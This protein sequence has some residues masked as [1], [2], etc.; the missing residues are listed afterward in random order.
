MV[1]KQSEIGRDAQLSMLMRH[2]WQAEIERAIDKV[3]LGVIP[4]KKRTK[5]DKWFKR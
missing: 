2:K 4:V 3:K 5:T 1:E